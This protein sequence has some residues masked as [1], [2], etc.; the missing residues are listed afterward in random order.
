MLRWIASTHIVHLHGQQALSDFISFRPTSDC[1]YNSPLPGLQF[2]VLQVAEKGFVS[3]LVRVGF[4]I[5]IIGAAMLSV[6]I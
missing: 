5:R 3:Y 2:M 1:E 6:C 4:L